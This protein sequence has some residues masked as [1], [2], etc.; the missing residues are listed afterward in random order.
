[1]ESESRV[2][3]AGEYRGLTDDAGEFGGVVVMLVDGGLHVD[4]SVDVDGFVLRTSSEDDVKFTSSST[5]CFRLFV[6][7]LICQCF[8]IVSRLEKRESRCLFNRMLYFVV[9]PVDVS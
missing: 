4:R 9:L 5:E 6:L 3:E 8:G 1:M 2:D 7:T